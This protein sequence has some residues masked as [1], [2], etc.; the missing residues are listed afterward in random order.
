MTPDDLKVLLDAVAAGS[1][2]TE[3]AH[4]QL[5]QLP[6][7][8]LG[9]ARIDHHRQLRTHFPE[10]VYGQSKTPE[11]ILS[12]LRAYQERSQLGIVT[13]LSADKSAAIEKAITEGEPLDYHYDPVSRLAWSGEVTPMDCRGTICVA[14]AGTSDLPVAEEA[15]KTIELLGQP[16]DRITDIGVAGLQRL[17][18]VRDRLEQAEIVVAVAGMEGALPGVLKGLIS[19][20]VIAVPASVGFGVSSG[21]IAALMG[22]LASCSPGLTV[23]NID[24]GFG[25][26]YAAAVM[27]RKRQANEQ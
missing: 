15:A 6:F 8:D 16:V 14:A 24:N 21:G 7:Q 10:V 20:P 12:I 23:V 3:S 9:F 17:L 13:R 25:A 19:R 4:Q 1:V 27:N 26:G 5:K 22:M 11:H 18:S 2:S